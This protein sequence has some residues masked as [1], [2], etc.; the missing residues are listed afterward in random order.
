MEII[1]RAIGLCKKLKETVSGLQA[2]VLKRFHSQKETS[3]IAPFTTYSSQH[4]DIDIIAGIY[5]LSV[6]VIEGPTTGLRAVII[7]NKVITVLIFPVFIV[8]LV[9]FQQQL[10]GCDGGG[11]D[12]HYY[13]RIQIPSWEQI[14]PSESFIG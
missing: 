3:I 4:S 14:T 6:I 8:L 1:T 13:C 10:Q 11:S 9:V 5:L 12:G 2:M 7:V